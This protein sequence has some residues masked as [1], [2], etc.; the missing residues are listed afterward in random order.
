MLIMHQLLS[1][2]LFPRLSPP[3][4]GLA[5]GE[6]AAALIRSSPA[7]RARALQDRFRSLA[8]FD[9]GLSKAGLGHR[10]GLRVEL[11]E[12]PTWSLP[13]E[14]P[15]LAHCSETITTAESALNTRSAMPTRFCA[16][17]N[18]ARCTLGISF[19]STS[20]GTAS[21]VDI[22]PQ[23]SGK[24]GSSMGRSLRITRRKFWYADRLR[25]G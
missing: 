15:Y 20:A 22:V 5:S 21:L 1:S 7:R 16:A 13:P 24:P 23:T 6:A 14:R 11:D 25:G 3:R 12:V 8:Q 9:D 10:S 18:T 4:A 19:Q 17:F 2:T